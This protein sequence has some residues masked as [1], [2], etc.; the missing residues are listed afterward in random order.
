MTNTYLHDAVDGART[1]SVIDELDTLLAVEGRPIRSRATVVGSDPLVPSPHRL[2]DATSAAIAAFG[3]QIA[4]IAE[5][6]GRAPQTVTV[7]AEDAIDQLRATY[8]TTVSGVPA[9]HLTEDPRALGN[10]D[11]YQC[12]DGRWIFLITTYAGLRD[13]VCQVLNCPPFPDRIADAAVHWDAYA[14]EDAV[15]AGG[16]VAAVVRSTEE[17]RATEMAR[18]L[19]GRGVIELEQIGPGPREALPGGADWPPLSSLRVADLTHVIAGPVSTRLLATFGA[20]VMHVSRPD[21]PDPISM[22][23]MTGG[24]KRN[25]FADLRNAEQRDAFRRLCAGADVVVDSYRGMDR[26]GFG[27]HDLAALRP[28]VVVCEYHCWGADGP[29]GERGGFDQLACSATGFA[30]SENFDGRPSLPPTYLL[31]DYLAAY[32]G[33]AGTVAALRRRAIMGGSWRVRVN[34]DRVCMWVQDLGLF[35]QDDVAA[36][37]RPSR[38]NI[39]LVTVDSPFGPITEPVL[40]LAFSDVPTPVWGVPRPL[41]SSPLQW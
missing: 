1:A 19:L 37:P 39:D 34:L 9:A 5:D 33:A 35:H 41:G 25:A 23:A 29:W 10:N 13:A 18:Y 32:L 20:D 28:G 4:G 17:W 36:L 31:N 24:G 38:P 21:L 27:A 6:A 16:G 15:V 8:L 3:L 30:E 22:V 11:F 2:A 26:R 14:L 7:R 40:P 12:R